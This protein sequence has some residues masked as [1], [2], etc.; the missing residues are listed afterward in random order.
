MAQLTGHQRSLIVHPVKG[1]KR[2][3]Q[4][5]WKSKD[6][7]SIT[8][9]QRIHLPSSRIAT[10]ENHIMIWN[11][12]PD[13]S[14]LYPYPMEFESFFAFS[15]FS[16]PASIFFDLA[17]GLGS[18]GS[19]PSA[20]QRNRATHGRFSWEIS[21]VNGNHGKRTYTY[22]I[23]YTRR[24]GREE[25]AVLLHKKQEPHTMMARIKNFWE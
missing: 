15:K 24:W 6:F 21:H 5:L 7:L 17:S 18:L 20:C 25:K 19:L 16:A 8:I 12:Q 13:H 22:I 11:H 1:L 23:I 4:P 9:I 3:Q 10:A 14:E 2:Q